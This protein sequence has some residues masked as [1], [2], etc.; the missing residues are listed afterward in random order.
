MTV[1]ISL[2]IVAGCMAY[3]LF[4]RAMKEVTL[5]G[6]IMSPFFI[7]IWP[8]IFII[9]VGSVAERFIIWRKK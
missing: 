4:L 5:L 8:I 3:V 6:V 7:C 9:I 1:F 2:Y